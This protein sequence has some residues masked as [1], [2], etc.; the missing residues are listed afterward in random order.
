MVLRS[1]WTAMAVGVVMTSASVAVGQTVEASGRPRPQSEEPT[2]A[3]KA[4]SV[5]GHLEVPHDPYVRV[6]LRDRVTSPAV[7]WT[8]GGYVSVQVNVDEFGDNIVGDAANEPSIAVDPTNP[9]RMAIGW[10]QFDTISSDFRQAGW[11]YTVDGG[12]SWTFP[13]RIE[14]GVFRSDPV[15]DSD[16]DGNFYYNSLTAD[17]TLS[18]FWCHVFKSTDGGVSW[19]SGTYA[20]G[21]DK[22]WQVIDLTDGIGRNNIY[23]VWNDAFSSCPNGHFTRS[24]DGGA[25]FPDCVPVTGSPYW[26]TMDVGPDGELY[27]AGQGFLVARSTTAQDPDHTVTWDSAVTLSL[28]GS[29]V[30]S[31][32]PNPAGL[33]GQAWVATDRSDGPTR[34]YVYM[35]CSVDPPGADPLDV[36]FARSTDG[37]QTWSSPVRVNDDLST[38]AWQWFGTMS[39][40]PNGRIDAIWNDTRGD[41]GGYNSVVYYSYSTD[42]GETWSR[43]EPISPE[44]DPHEGWPQQHKIGDYY[45]MV[46]DEFGANLAYS[47]TFNG[48]QDVYFVRIGDPPCP[49]AGRVSFDRGHFACESEAAV[50]VLDCGLNEDDELVETVTADVDSD[51]EPAGEVVELTETGPATA[52]FTGTIALSETDADGVLLVSEGDTVTVT[53]LDADDGE[54]GVD[55]EVTAIALVDCTPPVISD[56]AVTD[57]GPFDATVTFSTDEPA[58]GTVRYG[59]S[60][61]AL[62]GIAERGGLVSDHE[63]RLSGLIEDATYFFAVDAEDDAGNQTTDDNGGECYTFATTDVPNYF[64]QQFI[65]G[66]DLD[67]LSLTFVPNGSIDYYLGCVEEIDELPTDPAGGTAIS[68]IDDDYEE[69]SLGL[70]QVWL[71]GTP[72]NRIYVGGNGYVTFGSGDTEYMETLAAHFSLPRISALFDDLSPQSGGPVSWQQLGD[73]AVVTWEDVPEYSTSNTNTFQIEMFYD[74]TIRINYLRIDAQDAVA[75]LSAGGGV[76]EGFYETDLSGMGSCG[77]RPPSARSVSVSTP[78]YVPVEITLEATDD[79]LPEPPS[80]SLIVTSLPG[81]GTLTDLGAGAIES[82][83]YTLAEGGDTVLYSPNPCYTGQDSFQFKAN[84]GGEP[85][86]GGDSNPATVTLNMTRA[87]GTYQMIYSDPMDEDPGWTMEGQWA[88]GVPTGG[89]THDGDPTSGYTGDNVVGYNLSGDYTDGMP[90]YYVTTGAFDCRELTGVELRF[91][92]WLGVESSSFDHA[93]VEA[94]SDGSGWV[95]LW[96]HSGSA[97]SESSWSEQVYDLSALAD[98]EPTVY[99]RWSMGPTDS[100]VT[101]PGWNIDDVEIWGEPP[102]EPVGGDLNADGRVTLFDYSIFGACVTGPDGVTAADCECADVDTDGDVDLSD[103]RVIQHDME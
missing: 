1:V 22:Q 6:P 13:G 8:R 83:P 75:G 38:S 58:R 7:R 49:D 100:L 3:G 81:H 46:S 36:M 34:G 85:P 43:N 37:G 94:S 79:G 102:F 97:L 48:E 78:V 16:A 71:Y 69:I 27:V 20:H 32:G 90:V 86:E 84:D 56:V 72:Y 60:C 14:P 39:V 61:D 50:T 54:G 5:V 91:R 70:A 93:T 103:F 98:G 76:P 21:G 80:L 89:G 10:R 17:E 40:A 4:K 65:S 63:V 19:D 26:G 2:E 96:A 51:S 30:F 92:R 47:A 41:P 25:S 88:F 59:E 87:S 67:N 15:L 99:V 95:T 11:A 68:L 18:D 45:D 74:G 55:V 77:P 53:Y 35:L 82:V 42:A 101:Y 29:I 57:V 64:T 12:A 23:A 44:F 9:M 66:F 52:R 31:G 33:L 28:G 73:R 62:T 24:T